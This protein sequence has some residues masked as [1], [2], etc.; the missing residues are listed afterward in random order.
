ME[1]AASSTQGG[2]GLGGALTIDGGEAPE[3]RMERLLRESPVVVFSRPGCCMAHVM[4]RLLEAVGAHPTVIVLEEG[5]TTPGPAAAEA[6]PALFIGGA[7]VG[8]LE[9]LMALH[10]GGGLVPLLREAGA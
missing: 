6:M 5:E 4:R 8:G 9:G 3:R 10:L 2:L 1:I 7:A